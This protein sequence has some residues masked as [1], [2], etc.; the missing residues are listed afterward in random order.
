MCWARGDGQMLSLLKS[1]KGHWSESPSQLAVALRVFVS[2]SV[3]TSVRVS[4]QECVQCAPGHMSVCWRY[5]GAETDP[6]E[7]CSACVALALPLSP[8]TC[9]ARTFQSQDSGLV[10]PE[11]KLSTLRP[12]GRLAAA[13]ATTHGDR[14]GPW[15]CDSYRPARAVGSVR[16]SL[17]FPGAASGLFPREASSADPFLFLLNEKKLFFSY[18]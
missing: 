2:V 1:S 10:A 14:A 13:G 18:R 7:V 4:L 8:S 15:A 12:H 6:W 3:C 11:Q 16:A 9:T 17:G 5:P